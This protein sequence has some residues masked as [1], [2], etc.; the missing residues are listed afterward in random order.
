MGW[1]GFCDVQ[2]QIR[3]CVMVN[4]LNAKMAVLALVLLSLPAV[5]GAA[6]VTVGA[7]VTFVRA[8][9]IRVKDE[10]FTIGM[11]EAG[12]PVYNVQLTGTEKIIVIQ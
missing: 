5:A 2:K 1:R 4:P 7:S 12:A 10:S 11:T 8:E 3:G 6:R 9:K